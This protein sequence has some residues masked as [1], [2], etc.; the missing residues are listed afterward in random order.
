MSEDRRSWW[1]FDPDERPVPL[2]PITEAV[3]DEAEKIVET[4][5]QAIMR[6]DTDPTGETLAALREAAEAASAGNADDDGT[7]SLRRVALALLS[8]GCLAMFSLGWVQ[9]AAARAGAQISSSDRV[10]TP[11]NKDPRA[12]SNEGLR[13]TKHVGRTSKEVSRP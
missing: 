11:T 1:E 3:A 2:D 9:G 13:D 10:V 4:Q 5:R 12:G 8:V 7:G 6:E